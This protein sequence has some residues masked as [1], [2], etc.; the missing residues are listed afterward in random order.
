MQI[1]VA[2]ELDQPFETGRDEP[3]AHA[4]RQA[5]AEFHIG[6]RLLLAAGVAHDGAAAGQLVDRVVPNIEAIEEPGWIAGLHCLLDAACIESETDI[7][8]EGELDD[9]LDLEVDDAV[10]QLQ[11][12]DRVHVERLDVVGI[13]GIDVGIADLG[14]VQR[15]QVGRIADHHVVPGIDAQ[16]IGE[17]Q[18]RTGLR[19]A[20]G[21]GLAKFQGPHGRQA[22][23]TILD[24]RHA[25]DDFMTTGVGDILEG[26]EIVFLVRIQRH[27]GQFGA[28]QVGVVDRL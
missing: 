4:G 2:C 18:A 7:E 22:L 9:G 20:R 12:Q 11:Q 1:E 26:A 28:D 27:V 10:V 13:V 24:D 16:Q 23:N 19:P 25:V 15:H 3:D 5:D 17:L 8:R 14:Q 6:F 21:S